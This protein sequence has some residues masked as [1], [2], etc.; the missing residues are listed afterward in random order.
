MRAT[1]ACL[2]G[3]EQ[4]M[5]ILLQEAAPEGQLDFEYAWEALHDIRAVVRQM[6]PAPSIEPFVTR[7]QALEGQQ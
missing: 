3:N 2:S 6:E 7:I 1:L 5:D 4:D